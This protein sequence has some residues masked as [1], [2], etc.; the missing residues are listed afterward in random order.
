MME[1][2]KLYD[3][4]SGELSELIDSRR[5]ALRTKCEEYEKLRKQVCEIKEKYPNILAL[6][7]DNEVGNLNAVECKNL[8]KLLSLYSR[9]M[10]FEDSEIFF[11]GARENYF[12]F[13]NLEL[14]N[15]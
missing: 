5:I 10:D 11:L 7:E 14:I 1:D 13:K 9:M 15:E 4:D 3:I 8:Q 6:L 2:M 12:Y